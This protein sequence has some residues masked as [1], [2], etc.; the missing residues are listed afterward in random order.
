MPDPVDV[1]GEYHTV[2]QLLREADTV[3]EAARYE[4]R[5]RELRAIICREAAAQPEG[6][7]DGRQ[8]ESAGG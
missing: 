1:F 8:K 4:K 5:L 7:N 6:S 2:R 3:Q